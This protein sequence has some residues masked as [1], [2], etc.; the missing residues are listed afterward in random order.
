MR[1]RRRRVV[2]D[3][4]AA[5]PRYRARLEARVEQQLRAGTSVA[6]AEARCARGTDIAG[7]IIGFRNQAVGAIAEGRRVQ[8]HRIRRR[9]VAALQD[10]IHIELDLADTDVVAG[11]GR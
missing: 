6:D 4:A 3:A 11:G 5:L 2:D 1:R 7:G 10:V 9:R 8:R